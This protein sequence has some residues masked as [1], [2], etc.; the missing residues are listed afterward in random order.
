MGGWPKS[1]GPMVHITGIAR[2]HSW[3]EEVL[4]THDFN[5][6][7]MTITTKGCQRSG[8][9]HTYLGLPPFKIIFRTPNEI[10]DNLDTSFYQV[11]V[12]SKYTY[13][14]QRLKIVLEGACGRAVACYTAQWVHVIRHRIYIGVT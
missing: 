8:G 7:L 10:N 13:Q 1:L 11:A 2:N 12:K 9:L 6:H 5:M 14:I 4:N 3:S